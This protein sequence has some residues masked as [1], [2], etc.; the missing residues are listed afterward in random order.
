MMGKIKNFFSNVVTLALLLV[1][2]IGVVLFLSSHSQNGEPTAQTTRPTPTPV[3]EETPPTPTIA[4]TPT[5]QSDQP[6]DDRPEPTS[7]PV[8][9][10]PDAT[11]PPDPTSVPTPTSTPINP[12][13]SVLI[14]FD[15]PAGLGAVSPDGK[16]LAFNLLQTKT[17]PGVNPHSQVWLLDLESKQITKLAEVGAV[18]LGQVVWSPDG[19]TLAYHLFSSN[20]FLEEVKIV[21]IDGSNDRSLLKNEDLLSYYWTDSAHMGLIRTT[22]VDQVD[23]TGRVVDEKAVNLPTGKTD[24]A[25]FQPKPKVVGSS[26]DIVIVLENGSLMVISQNN[27]TTISDDRGWWINDFELAP[28]GKQIAYVTSNGPEEAFWVSDLSGNNRRKIFERVGEERGHIGSMLWS[29]DS[30]AVVLG[31]SEPGTSQYLTLTWVDVVSE[32]VTPLGVD[33][34]NFSGLAFS[35]D[36]QYL[37]YDRISYLRNSEWGES[38]FYQLKVK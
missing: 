10:L 18:G 11:S 24:P 28:D 19:K 1:L 13:E 14:S 23:L 35:P 25:D 30:Q 3:V 9:V 29:P 8:I 34:V 36:G 26:Q 12:N 21:G 27:Q 31:W 7:T 4:L 17:E 16:I 15:V 22:S 37:Y 6:E 20:G 2:G 32:K 38:T 33:G 5:I